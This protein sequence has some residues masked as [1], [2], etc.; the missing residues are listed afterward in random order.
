MEKELED[1][2]A[3]QIPGTVKVLDQ[4]SEFIKPERV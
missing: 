3:F 4:P 2:Y 1:A